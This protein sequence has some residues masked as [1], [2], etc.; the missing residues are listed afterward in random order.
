MPAR[1]R[2]TRSSRWRARAAEGP[3]P[4]SRIHAMAP[5]ARAASHR[6]RG[7]PRS[8]NTGPRA[9]SAMGGAHP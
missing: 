7:E 1:R 8:P 9:A 4:W 3:H 2:R 5:A 6:P